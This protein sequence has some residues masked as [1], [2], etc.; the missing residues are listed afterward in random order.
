MKPRALSLPLFLSGL[1]SAKAAV[2]PVVPLPDVKGTFDATVFIVPLAKEK[3]QSILPKG[4]ELAPQTS[5]SEDKHPVLVILGK[6][7]RVRNVM[8]SSTLPYEFN[9]TE[10]VVAIPYTQVSKNRLRGVKYRGPYYFMPKIFLDNAV[11][12]ILGLPYGYEKVQSAF[13]LAPK[14]VEGKTYASYSISKGGKTFVSALSQAASEVGS[15]ED[16]ANFAEVQQMLD[17]PIIGIRKDGFTC[18]SFDWNKDNNLQIQSI[19]ASLRV[20]SPLVHGGIG[21]FDFSSKGIARA[22]LG[23]F[24]ILSDWHMVG[25]FNCRLLKN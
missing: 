20:A 6:Q 19:T 18:S 16:F 3:V 22:K 1:L 15:P 21:P 8:G 14:K 24:N 13:A 12:Q 5:T 25:P 23:A 2:L 10:T 9:Y 4:L 7:K 17:Q 11:P